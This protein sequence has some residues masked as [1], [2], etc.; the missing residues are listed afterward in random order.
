MVLWAHIAEVLA[1]L[2]V[3][4]CLYVVVGT[5]LTLVWPLHQLSGPWL[6]CGSTQKALDLSQRERTQESHPPPCAA[7]VGSLIPASA[8]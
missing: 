7:Q 1:P 4:S 5:G 3:S 6:E 2:G 8:W